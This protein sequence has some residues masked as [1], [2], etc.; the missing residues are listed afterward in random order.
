MVDSGIL[1]WCLNGLQ[2]RIKSTR[3]RRGCDYHLGLTIGVLSAAA[4]HDGPLLQKLPLLAAG[5]PRHQR[6]SSWSR[7]GGTIV[8]SLGD[9]IKVEHG[10]SL[11]N[12]LV[13]GGS[14]NY[15]DAAFSSPWI[16]Q[17]RQHGCDPWDPN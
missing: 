7:F 5:D 13:C 4:L 9:K 1:Y 3:G 10:R 11:R 14:L 15:I 2:Q 17:S 8:A 6:R 12:P 16:H